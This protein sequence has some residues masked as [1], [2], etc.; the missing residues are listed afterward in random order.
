MQATQNNFPL[1]V[2]SE[3][4]YGQILAVLMRR[5]LWLIGVFIVCVGAS[6]VLAVRQR[7]SY[8]SLMQLLVEPYYQE[9]PGKGFT[10]EENFADTSVQIDS[11][12]QISL[13]QSSGLLKKAMK[14]LQVEYPELNPEIPGSIERFKSN[15]T[16]SQVIK[17]AGGN[18]KAETKIFQIIY[19]DGNPTKTQRV[20]AAVQKVYQD[21]N[22]EQQRIRLS[23]GLNFVNDQL[24][25]VKEKVS[26]AEAALEKFRTQQ[27]LVDPEAQARLSVEILSR[28]EQEGRTL[29][30]QIQDL[31]S[32][33]I[34]LQNQLGLD[35]QQAQ[36]A[37]RL[38]Q[39]A[40]YQSLLNEIQKTELELVKQ[41]LRFK[42]GTQYVQIFQ[43][44]RQRQL[45]LLQNEVSR[46][47]GPLSATSGQSEQ[48]LSAGQL[49]GLDLNLVNQLIDVQVNLRAS[50]ARYQSLLVAQQQVRSEIQKFPNLLAQYGRLLPEIESNRATLKQLL[51]AQQDI[52]LE[53]ARGGFDW[54]VVEE[55]QVGAKT[56]SSPLRFLLLGAVV[57]LFL[58]GAAA[59]AREAIDDAVHSSEDLKKQI[60]VP[61]L[62][63][64][65]A[66]SPQLAAAQS[67]VSLAT[68]P[69]TELAPVAMQVI[70]WQ[71]F[72]ESL[73]LLYQNIQLLGGNTPFK[74]LVITSALAGEGK[75]TLAL[76]L[77]VSAARLHQRVLLID[78]DLRRPTL[79]KLLSLPNDRGLS[80]LLSSNTP[81]PDHID[82]QDSNIRTN[83]S[84][85]TAGPSPKDPAKLLSS[86]RMREVMQTFEQSYDLVL[87]D[88][89]PVSGMVDTMMAASCCNGVVMV[90]RINRVTRTELTQAAT[91]L[92]KLNVIGVVANGAG[93][94]GRSDN[95]Y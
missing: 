61:L 81:V 47:L 77:A 10:G 59:F 44:Q 89:P 85:L 68:D 88:T 60:P 46:V 18:R 31:N 72:R 42:D 1:K 48:L 30:T 35:P 83:I 17:E 92:S 94:P 12:T 84:I 62:G 70:Q 51:K 87:L 34:N 28:I 20:L 23:R 6:S 93:L 80:S 9:K 57:G 41:R 86:A 66:L 22:L 16:V 24:P 54:Q 26:E 13:M 69:Q 40:R 67:S 7:P 39:S 91:M 78:A 64:I 3:T 53:I 5:R 19:T 11:A 33:Y 32:R 27:G 58:G 25:Q 15:L 75:S 52:G 36:I 79:H 45:G 38:S 63:V 76:G 95:H 14:T 21:Y 73:D 49:G 37:S 50:E 43:D 4:G 29:L 90:G 56:G 2:E 74:S 8:V 71:P 65:P 82:T 55:P